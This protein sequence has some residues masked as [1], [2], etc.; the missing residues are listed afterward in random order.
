MLDEKGDFKQRCNLAMVDLDPLIEAEE[1]DVIKELLK[2]HVRH[3]QST[4]AEKLLAHWKAAQPKFVK[5]M[6]KD[7]KRVLIAIHKARQS[8]VS[9]D[10]AVME[11]SH[12]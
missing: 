6:P 5:V 10:Q 1:V 7:Y 3:T 4:V 2:R 12:G 8:G 11:A 9:E